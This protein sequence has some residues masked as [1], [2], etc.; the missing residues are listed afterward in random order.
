VVWI[1]VSV[2][3]IGLFGTLSKPKIAATC[4]TGTASLTPAASL[5]AASPARLGRDRAMRIPTVSRARD[6]ICSLAASLPWR[7]YVTTWN[8]TA[9]DDVEAPLE[10]WMVRPEVRVPKAH[11]VS[12]TVDD[13]IFFGFS[14]WYITETYSDGRPARFQRLPASDVLI[15]A[16]NFANGVPIG[17]FTI[18]YMG[19]VI[20]QSRVVMFWSPI[21]PLLSTAART[22]LISERLDQA[23]MRFASSPTAFGWLRQTGGEPMSGDDLSELAESWSAARDTGAVGALSPDVEW[24][25]STMDPSKMQLVEARQ[26]QALEVA[27]HANIPPYLV[28]VNAAGFTYS[29]AE[30]SVRDLYLFGALPY[31]ET[32]GQ[33]LSSDF[34]VARSHIIKLEASERM[35]EERPEDVP[36]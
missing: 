14:C 12:W 26:Y 18:S 31:I 29:N 13:L 20:P 3:R 6:L 2:G 36:T 33:T 27:R 16:D 11:T 28:G 15:D 9:Y 19:A 32:I 24:V 30:Q 22:L 21:A 25:E 8:G 17:D 10:P 4:A 35:T 1:A 34:V 23:A 7:H 5:V